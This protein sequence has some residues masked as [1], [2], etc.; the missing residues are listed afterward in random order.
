MKKIISKV[1][2]KKSGKSALDL[3]IAGMMLAV[4]IFMVVTW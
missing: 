2:T 4:M 1:S 3:V